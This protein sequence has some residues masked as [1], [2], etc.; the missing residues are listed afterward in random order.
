MKKIFLVM[1]LLTVCVVASF[2][3]KAQAHAQV[4]SQLQSQPLF[5][6]YFDPQ[7]ICVRYLHTGN[8]YE[9]SF[10]VK[11]YESQGVWAKSLVNL[12]DKFE[13]G[14]QKV[15]LYDLASGEL[16]YSYSYNTLF[17]EYRTTEA[18]RNYKVAKTFRE[19]VLVP[20]PKEAV[21]MVFY[22]RDLQMQYAVRHEIVFDPA[23]QKVK[24]VKQKNEVIESH[25]VAEPAK[26]YDL[27]IVPEGYAVADSAKLRRDVERCTQAI[28][29]CSPYKDNA[30]RLNIRAVVA[31]SKQSGIS[32]ETDSVTVRKTVAAA[33]FY[34]FGTE[35]YLMAEDVW[36]LHRIA[37]HV[38]Y[39]HILLLCNTSK[40]GGGGIFN[41]YSTVSDNE[42]F[43][44]VCI[45]E[46][47]HGIAGLADEYYTSEVAVQDFYPENAEPREPNITNL[48][49]FEEKW[50]DMIVMSM[51]TP[52]PPTKK[53]DGKVGL[54]EGGGYCA[55]GIYRPCL[56]CSMKEILYD[57]FCPVCV[58]A[59]QRM[60]DFCCDK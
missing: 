3:F 19:C 47:G 57:R 28:L 56:H 24:P 22:S 26:A 5:S 33:S 20:L 25:V 54:F 13:Y 40:Y 11:G 38:P 51:P 58:R 4:Q 36:R 7:T 37:A 45:H 23:K 27:L 32:R 44:Y 12:I 15:E 21:R 43:D 41:F 10:Q 16:L 48:V 52:T 2:Q 34:T 50:Q 60:F 59:F 39:E 31:Y 9:E 30:Y 49:Q 42:H 29:Q 46:L 53:Y 18:G 8:Y 35:R 17:S 55:K 14:Y 1:L 6:K